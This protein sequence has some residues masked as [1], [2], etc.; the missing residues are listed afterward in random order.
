M[1]R[2]PAASRSTPS[3]LAQITLDPAS[4]AS[5]NFEA[6]APLIKTIQDTDSE[7]LYLQ[8]LDRF[9]GE[10]EKEIEKICENNYEV[11]DCTSHADTQEFVS[12]VLALSSV[13]QGTG[14]LRKRIG[15]LDGQMGD[16]GR[17][18]GEKV[19]QHGWC[20]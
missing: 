6:L 9:V 13:R 17:G 16:V 12:S 3:D 7:Q 19:G 20:G 5:E 11:G 15:E 2:S 1:R 18:L 8:S 4:G 10:K 14:Q